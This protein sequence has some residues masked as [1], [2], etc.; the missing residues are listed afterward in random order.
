MIQKKVN[1]L[2]YQVKNFNFLQNDV[3]ELKKKVNDHED[4]LKYHNSNIIDSK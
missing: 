4:E 2:D 1:Y 3:S